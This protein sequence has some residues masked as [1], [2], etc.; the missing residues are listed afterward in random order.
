MVFSYARK[1]VKR[2][3][4][5]TITF[6]TDL[7]N[8]QLEKE[9][10]KL[11]QKIKKAEEDLNQKE[12]E[13]SNLKQQLDE[14]TAAAKETED[15][16][17]R[18]KAEQERLNKITS[19]VNP[20]AEPSD[21][22]EY[23]V[24]LE[25]Q[26]RIA[27]ELQSQQKILS[28]QDKT[29]ERIAN[30]YTQCTDKVNEMTAS[31]NRMQEQAGELT[32][33]IEASYSGE[34]RIGDAA[35]QAGKQMDK[36][37]GRV[38][39]LAVN[40]FVFNLISKGFSE[41]TNWIGKVIQAD[42]EASAA[43]AQ[44]KGAL[45]TMVQP[46][47]SIVVPAFTALVNVLTRV[48]TLISRLF[49]NL[50]GLS[51][52][53][54][55]ASA[56][57]LYEKTNA[58]EEVGGAAKEAS[59][60]LAGFDELNVMQD[61]SD[62]GSLGS[63]ADTSSPDFDFDTALITDKLDQIA[64]YVAGSLLALGAVLTFSGAS[65]PLG[66][67][68]MALG[69]VTLAAEIRE[70]WGA[71]DSEVGNAINIVLGTLAAAGLVI[72]AILAFSGA[73]IP[74][75]IGLMAVGAAALGTVVAL[76]WDSISNN[77]EEILCA[78]ELVLGAAVLA[79]GAIL[80]FTGANV[81]LGVAMLV[82]GAYALYQATV[83]NWDTLSQALQGPIGAITAMVSAALL[84]L[85]IILVATGAG[86]PLGVALIMA[87][88][89]ALVKVASVNWNWMQEKLSEVWRNVSH[90]FMTNVYPYFTKEYWVNKIFN[91]LSE[92]LP[93]SWKAAINSAITL[94][95]SFISWVN[96]TL[97]F[98]IPTISIAGQTVF[99]GATLQ[100]VNLPQIPY[101]AQG[102]VIPPNREFMAVLGDQ[103]HGNNI[104]APESL[105]RKIVR[106][107]T[108]GLGSNDR[109]EQLLEA[110]ISVVE[111][112]EIGDETIGKAAARYTRR[113][114]RARGV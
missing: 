36:F 18:L 61:N 102:A 98:D 23:L 60:Y 79:I 9:L 39:K 8:E 6:R 68:L 105:I 74:L 58:I 16:I 83:V 54:T 53:D 95:N 70:N 71:M 13:Q 75:G 57:A 2:L 93:E 45:L 69:A 100:L 86:V 90:W 7:D 107:E 62:S 73:N 11:I 108:A 67:G 81:P 56:K 24:A 114:S 10:S 85:G 91:G 21:P 59:R 41:L 51:Y 47:V 14:A 12:S 32:Q 27:E 48:I 33:S 99:S 84:V 35:E 89:G 1:R 97:T 38:K 17:K 46:I 40:A 113:T 72:G 112:I 28:E 42:D 96:R 4:D 29:A 15:A 65:I 44:L 110:L 109:V 63:I 103:T 34:D 31:L 20:G 43:I 101:L 3:A 19:I 104:E 50:F 76:N 30:K 64:V 77:I 94:I 25:N 80:T 88:A 78:L 37:L 26:K 87:G 82:A 92:A 106:E 49:G 66:L 5:G 111:G 22:Y 55:K 52:S